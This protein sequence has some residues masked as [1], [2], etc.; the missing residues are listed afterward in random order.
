MRPYPPN[1]PQ[2]AARILALALLADGAIDPSEL[3]S[4][5]ERHVLD[6]LGMSE[7][8]FDA[9]IHELCEDLLCHA[10][11]APN[12]QL[13][14][15]RDCLRQVLGELTLRRLQRRVLQTVL[16]IVHADGYLSGGEA[17]L[18]TLALEC[19]SFE[20]H[21]TLRVTPLPGR[22]WPPHVARIGRGGMAVMAG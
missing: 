16:D 7:R 22:R 14:V 21:E 12:G 1:S 18:V 9:V 6:R 10:E 13:E 20:A 2:A 8:D 19:W 4:L 11:R 5:K 3:R 17:M 15:G